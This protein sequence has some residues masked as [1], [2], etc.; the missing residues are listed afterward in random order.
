MAT[1]KGQVTNDIAVS[2]IMSQAPETV[3]LR[4]VVEERIDR[5]HEG[6][7]PDAARVLAEHP[8]L[9]SKKSL[10]LELVCEEYSLRTAAGDRI[11]KSD[12]CDRFPAYRQSIAKMLEV[13]E[14]LDRC[15]PLEPARETVRWPLPGEK[16]LGYDIVEPLGRGGLARVFLAR[17]RE[18]GGRFVVI[19]VSR[20]GDREAHALGKLSHPGIVPI[21]SVQQDDERGLTVICMPLVGVAT[22]IDLLDAAFRAGSP[23]REGKVIGR[24]A[25][26]AAPMTS[27][28]RPGASEAV[29]YEKLPYSEAIARLGLELAEAL[30]AAH[31]AGIQHRDIKP[32][33][34]LL[35]W[36]GQPM[37]LDFNLSVDAAAA[38]NRVG[39]T[40]AYMAP[41]LIECL[42]D[43]NDD[44]AR[45]FQPRADIYSLGVV[46][47]ELLTGKL[48]AKPLGA[49]RLEPDDY[50][51]WLASKRQPLA[52]DLAV[53]SHL[54]RIVMKCLAA[55]SAARYAS[56]DELVAE[57]RDYLSTHSVAARR[58]RRR[59]AMTLVAALALLCGA[60]GAATYVGTRPP[61][62]EELYNQ[63]L[64]NYEQGDY[65]SAVKA[66]TECMR[67][68]PEWPEAIFGRA[69]SLRQLKRWEAARSD[70]LTL[71][72]FDRA[73]ANALA[74][75]CNMQR[76]RY[77]DA[78]DDFWK[79]HLAGLRDVGF[80]L[81]Y[82]SSEFSRQSP[83]RAVP[84]YSEVLDIESHNG[85][86]LRNRGL[87]Y[88]SVVR[89]RKDL[90]N[91]RAFEDARAYYRL[92]SESIDGP[93]CAAIIFGEAARKNSP[94]KEQYKEEA[95]RY[96]RQAIAQ[97]MPR[98]LI[99]KYPLALNPLADDEIRAQAPS[100]PNFVLDLRPI[101]E[102]PRTAAWNDFRREVGARQS[103]IAQVP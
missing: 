24:V 28:P 78:S 99:Q 39:G 66:F 2:C 27:V 103:L 70:Y 62:V 11:S 16:L 29:S 10:V 77:P 93:Y 87:A 100:D 21:H 41:E 23:P 48:P 30:A 12:F 85:I 13:E 31:A 50:A 98:E 74:G 86:A 19:K 9:E 91:P 64:A 92:E 65:D 18:V 63:A 80:L 47:Y 45:R 84:L 54:E 60:V 76:R 20:F 94:L 25:Q 75:Y 96:L 72:A 7:Q 46:L 57:L 36:S 68:K 58:A 8:E 97:G 1:D 37:L 101:Q 49:E 71:E 14:F 33:N 42:L 67:L 26:E 79:A 83:L 89:D 82:A 51:S 44:E 95:L 90:P 52:D 102:P 40:L 32:S 15:P 3:D 81:N 73:W 22:A 88:V 38:A 34:I 4:S 53:D 56:A 61:Y 55:D 6:A 17:E 5:W 69:Q 43:A 35:A 59:R